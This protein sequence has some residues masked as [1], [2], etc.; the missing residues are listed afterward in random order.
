MLCSRLSVLCREVRSLTTNP[1]NGQEPSLQVDEWRGTHAV[2]VKKAESQTMNTQFVL[3]LHVY[4]PSRRSRISSPHLTPL[5]PST[6]MPHLLDLPPEIHCLVAEEVAIGD[7]PATW[8]CKSLQSLRLACKALYAASVDIFGIAF[9][10]KRNHVV[11]RYRIGELLTITEHPAFG[12]CVR[13][14]QIEVSCKETVDSE[15]RPLVNKDVFV[16]SGSFCGVMQKVFENIK[17][18]GNSVDIVVCA[19]EGGGSFGWEKLAVGKDTFY[20]ISHTLRQTLEAADLSKVTVRDL[21][22]EL[23]DCEYMT[24]FVSQG[25]VDALEE[26]VA[27]C[28]TARI[29]DNINFRFAGGDDCNSSIS[30]NADERLLELDGDH[31]QLEDDCSDYVFDNWIANRP[32]RRLD[33]SDCELYGTGEEIVARYFKPFRDLQEI[34]FD[35]VLLDKDPDWSAILNYLA[36]HHNL[37]R[38]SLSKLECWIDTGIRGRYVTDLPGG[39]ATFDAEGDAVAPGLREIATLPKKSA[40]TSR[41]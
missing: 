34:R 18:F 14:V 38:C 12:P 37:V 8:D 6:I 27:E 26:A 23:R 19:S 4:Q 36:S 33:I 31:I 16:C 32:V 24:F 39:Y 30:Y 2:I 13:S 28:L 11:S 41:L 40:A 1:Q 25:E 9:F 10:V 29:D 7:E 3:L 17:H 21:S 20:P 5:I 15:T 22:I 35:R